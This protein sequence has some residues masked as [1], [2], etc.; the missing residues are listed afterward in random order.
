MA[1]VLNFQKGIDFIKNGLY[2][3]LSEDNPFIKGVFR[4]ESDKFAPN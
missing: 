4:D 3:Q 1:Y 2:D